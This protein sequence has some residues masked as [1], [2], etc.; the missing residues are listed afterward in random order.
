[1]N[2]PN[3]RPTILTI[4]LSVRLYGHI[5]MGATQRQAALLVNIKERTLSEWL[6]RGGREPT[7]IYRDLYESLVTARH[8]YRVGARER[9]RRLQLV[10][11]ELALLR[12]SGEPHRGHRSK[13]DCGAPG[14]GF[15]FGPSK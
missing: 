15:P 11:E 7:G 14:V 9:D 12:S 10:A 3:G 1:M 4:D 13:L 5:A 8:E 2:R 6:H